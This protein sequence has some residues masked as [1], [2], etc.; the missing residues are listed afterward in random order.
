MMN[1][2]DDHYLTLGINK[3]ASKAEIDNTYKDL[4]KRWH[5][6][7]CSDKKF[8][9]QKLA[10]IN[11]AY[12]ILGNDM[13]KHKYDA[14]LQ[15]EEDYENNYYDQ[16]TYDTPSSLFSSSSTESS[17]DMHKFKRQ[18]RELNEEMEKNGMP[19]EKIN[20]DFDSDVEFHDSENDPILDTPY[21][22]KLYELISGEVHRTK[23]CTLH[24]DLYLTL[25]D[26]HQAKER[27]IV[28]QRRTSQYNYEPYVFSFPIRR[29]M[30][31]GEEVH[32]DYCGHCVDE[33]GILTR[34]SGICN[35]HI[36]II[37]HDVFT[38]IGSNLYATFEISLNEAKNGFTRQLADL[39]GKIHNINVEKLERSDYM[40][41][42]R[43]R[44]IKKFDGFR[45]DIFV[46]FAVRLI[47]C[48]NKIDLNP[49]RKSNPNKK[50]IAQSNV[51]IKSQEHKFYNKKENSDT[52][53]YSDSE[54]SYNT[55]T[56]SIGN[57][58]SDRHNNTSK[59]NKFPTAP[60]TPI[61]SPT[62]NV[63]S[64]KKRGRPSKLKTLD[65]NSNNSEDEKL[66]KIK[67]SKKSKK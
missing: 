36:H 49:L 25:E 16:D 1:T 65:L 9:Q 38:K 18:L 5:P 21:K 8:A 29:N 67:K 17:M 59:S 66:V 30:Y 28:V 55:D 23:G 44:G 62:K 39:D 51:T 60:T 57:V 14:L 10:E 47:T 24:F 20:T 63:V 7:K 54:I 6:D 15:K 43:G 3:T 41:V 45:G 48:P 32:V 4:V 64:Q 33:Y 13:E 19:W 37:T 12:E 56:N 35:V 58:H 53:S 26:L 31:D 46:N 34:E 42:I 2:L 52:E 50:P 22:Q 27:T 61:E 40:Y 11:K